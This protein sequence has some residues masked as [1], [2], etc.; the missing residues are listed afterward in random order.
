[1]FQKHL[2]WAREMTQWLKA[3]DFAEDLGPIPNT[4]VTA[5]KYQFQ[6]NECPL[7]TS[8]GTRHACSAQTFIYIKQIHVFKKIT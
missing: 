7:L 1:M 4:H 6:G 8:A 5:H 2:M 3:L